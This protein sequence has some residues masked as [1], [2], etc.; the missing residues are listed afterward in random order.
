VYTKTG[1]GGLRALDQA[2]PFVEADRFDPDNRDPPIVSLAAMAGTGSV[3]WCG[4]KRA[5]AYRYPLLGTNVT[6]ALFRTVTC[7]AC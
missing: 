5:R 2:L 3:P 4:V 6:A 7:K 1:A